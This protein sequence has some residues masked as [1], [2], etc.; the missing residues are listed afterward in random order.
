MIFINQ[1]VTD[2]FSN[3]VDALCQTDGP[4]FVIS[5]NRFK[6]WQ[7]VKLL[8]CCMLQKHTPLRR[9]ITWG[10]FT[11]QT[12]FWLLRHARNQHVLFVTNPPMAMWMAPFFKIHRGYRYSLLIYDIYP[13]ALLVS[14]ILPETTLIGRLWR[15]MNALTL[16][17][18]E[19][20]ITLGER[21]AET[22]QG[23]MPDGSKLEIAVIENWVDTDVFKPLSRSRNPIVQELGLENKFIVAYAGA[24][25]ATHGIETILYCADMMKDH[26]NI[27]F[28]LVGSGTEENAVRKHIRENTLT[29][30]TLLPFQPRER[31]CHVAAAPDVSLVLLKT[32]GGRVSVPSK[33]YTALASGTAVLAVAGADS[34]LAASVM[35][36]GYGRVIPPDDPKAMAGVILLLARDPDLLSGL[37]TKAREIALQFHARENQCRKYR[38]LFHPLSIGFQKNDLMAPS[39]S[40]GNTER[41]IF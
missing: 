30:L 6:H 3:V 41:L 5:G 15:K 23:Q 16:R 34:D 27:H 33:V 32:G 37:K 20:V 8:K 39:T 38:R 14:G 4:H 11:L 12:F 1:S 25:G 40:S 31:F 22:L 26:P 21:M 19:N 17:G 28:L 24:F 29:N 36:H 10:L 13:D 35:R 7:N 9:I 18:A 2:L